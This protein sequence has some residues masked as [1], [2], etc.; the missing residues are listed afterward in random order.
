MLI[1]LVVENWKSFPTLEFSAVAGKE[2]RHRSRVPVVEKPRMRLTPISAVYGGNASGKSN[3]FEAVEFARRLVVNG[4]G[5]P[6]DRPIEVKPFRLNSA[7]PKEPTRFMFEI[8]TDKG[9]F[10]YAFTIAR[11]EIAEE[12]LT[13]LLQTVDKPV[14]ERRGADIKLKRRMPEQD[15][16]EYVGRGTRKNILFLTNSVSQNCVG[17]RHIY[18]WFSETL[19][20]LSPNS[21]CNVF[22]MYADE[23]SPFQPHNQETLDDFDVGIERIDLIDTPLE[24]APALAALLKKCADMPDGT[25]LCRDSYLVR[26]NAG[27]ISLSKMVAVHSLEDDARS[28]VQF[29]L[30]DESDGTR[31]LLNLIPTFTLLLHAS[32][33]RVVF[34]DEIDRSMHHLLTRKLIT[35]YL[36]NCSAASRSQLFFTTHDPLLMDQSLLRRDELWIVDKADGRRSQ[37]LCVD[38]FNV[39]HDK[40][41]VNSYLIGRFGGVPNLRRSWPYVGDKK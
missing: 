18:D 32:R 25:A 15:A 1:R 4:M 19:L 17:F 35:D 11:G 40:A 16:L 5:I 9:A 28:T 8:L 3:F 38:D 23:N 29:E 2:Q 14:F 37:L 7:A 30:D 33:P 34:I 6:L 13:E 36:V 27:E 24:Q 20:T 10:R 39:R 21:L 22:E 41:L 26:K 12:S 31:R